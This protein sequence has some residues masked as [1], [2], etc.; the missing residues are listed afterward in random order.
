[1]T[2]RDPATVAIRERLQAPDYRLQ[3]ALRA[4]LTPSRIAEDLDTTC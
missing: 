2:G 4:E 1:M 3:A